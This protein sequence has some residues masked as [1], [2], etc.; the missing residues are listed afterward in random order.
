MLAIELLALVLLLGTLSIVIRLV[1][2]AVTSS[3]ERARERRSRQRDMQEDLR[4]ALRA[5][6]H[7]RL[8]DFMVLWGSLVDEKT[9]QHV[10]SR[11]DELYVDSNGG[12]P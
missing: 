5:S 7:R 8:D 9:A 4:S 2:N 11:R 10:R 12:T 6:D 1:W 3:A